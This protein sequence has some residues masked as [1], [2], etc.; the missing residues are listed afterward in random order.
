MI[1]CVNSFVLFDESFKFKSKNHDVGLISMFGSTEVNKLINDG[2]ALAE[3]N[4][5]EIKFQ[6]IPNIHLNYINLRWQGYKTA[7]SLAI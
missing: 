7:K 5:D 2:V 3:Y 4:R 1:H 6:L